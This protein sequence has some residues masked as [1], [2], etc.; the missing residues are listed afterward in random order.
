MPVDVH[1]LDGTLP[2][3]LPE[4]TPGHEAAGDRTGWAGVPVP[5]SPGSARCSSPGGSAA[6]VRPAPAGSS[7][8]APIR[9]SWD[10]TTTVPGP[11]SSSYVCALAAFGDDLPF[12]Q[13]AILAD[14]VATPYAG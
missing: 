14:A 3:P 12:E 4:V 6:S 9:R 7:S 10:S 11:N 1:L 5:G 13:A 8:S 2:A